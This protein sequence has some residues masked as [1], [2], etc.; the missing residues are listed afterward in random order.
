MKV[1]ARHFPLPRKESGERKGKEER[2]GRPPD[3]GR[4]LV[5]WA[6]CDR[7]RTHALHT[8]A[9]IEVLCGP[10]KTIFAH[11]RRRRILGCADLW[12][13]GHTSVTR[14]VLFLQGVAQRFGRHFVVVVVVVIV[15][16]TGGRLFCVGTEGSSEE[17][18]VWD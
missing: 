2:L 15:V 17:G 12:N 3:W 1:V 13:S 16:S 9:A 14:C 18:R 5:K 11:R 10:S 4:D 6:F 8:Q 7:N